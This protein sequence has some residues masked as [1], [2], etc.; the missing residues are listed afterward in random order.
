MRRLIVNADDLGR[1]HGINTGVFE[2]HGL[3]IVTSA[4]AMVN[5]ESVH[6]AAAMS[7]ANPKL[8]IGLHVALSGGRPALPAS[9]APSLVDARGLQPR[10]PEGLDGANPV[11]IA[12]EIEA[13]LKRFVEVFGRKPTHL[14]SHHHSHRRPDVF[15]ALCAIA[16]R[17]GLPVRNAGGDMGVELKRLGIRT[18]DAFEESFFDQGVSVAHLIFILER[19]P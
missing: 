11:E 1:T 6:E 3:G 19:L 2:A 7:R 15:E 16:R 8:G 14:D 13:Q 5:Y 17:E 12:A 18:N 10:K 9:V 4:S